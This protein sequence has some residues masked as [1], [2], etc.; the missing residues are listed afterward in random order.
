MRVRCRLRHG[1]HQVSPSRLCGSGGGRGGRAEE[2][3]NDYDRDQKALDAAHGAQAID[4]IATQRCH[5]NDRRSN[6]KR[7]PSPINL[8]AYGRTI[9]RDLLVRVTETTAYQ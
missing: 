4:V 8:Q 3:E 1:R 9:N 5:P 2:R 7:G 6:G